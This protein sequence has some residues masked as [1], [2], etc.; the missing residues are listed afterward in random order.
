MIEATGPELERRREILDMI[1]DWTGDD[2]PIKLP[3][4]DDSRTAAA[5]VALLG[6]LDEPGSFGGA[7]GSFNYLFEGEEDL[8]HLI[9]ARKDRSPIAVEEAQTVA[10]FLLPG[11]E[12][13]TIWIKPG[14]LTHHF[15]LG[16]DLLVDSWTR[17]QAKSAL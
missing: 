13:A 14:T 6:C 9:V 2:R 12:P 8:L 3:P 17:L 15:Y 16:H 10:S 4:F 5:E 1:R 11:V 7:V